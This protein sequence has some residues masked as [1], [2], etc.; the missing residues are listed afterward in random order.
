MSSRKACLEDRG[1]GAPTSRRRSSRCLFA[2]RALREGRGIPGRLDRVAVG[3]EPEVG[4]L[5]EHAEK[6]GARKSLGKELEP[7]CFV[8]A[9]FASRLQL[10]EG[11]FA[12]HAVAAM[13]V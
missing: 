2:V 6:G 3:E 11:H 9:R 10:R 1:T 8:G 13:V 12:V 5:S 4:E 7:G